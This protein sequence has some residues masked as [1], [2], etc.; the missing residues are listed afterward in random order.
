M[1]RSALD[2]RRRREAV[3]IDGLIAKPD[4]ILV[5]PSERLLEQSR[6]R[7]TRRHGA[8]DDIELGLVHV[9]PCKRPRLVGV[10]GELKLM[11]FD[12]VDGVPDDARH[13]GVAC[14][15][16]RWSIHWRSA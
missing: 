16:S 1:S 14:Y 8:L 11:P 9:Y 3:G 10:G 7:I 2:A 4:S 12:A 15:Q 13:H 5:E 6:L